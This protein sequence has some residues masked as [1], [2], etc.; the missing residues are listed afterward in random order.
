[1]KIVALLVAAVAALAST[2][3][4]AWWGPRTYGYYGYYGGGP[5]YFD[6]PRPFLYSPTYY[7]APRPYVYAAPV[8]YSYYAPTPV[9]YAPPVVYSAPIAT[10]YVGPV[11]NTSYYTPVVT[12]YY[13]T[14]YVAP[15]AGYVR[16]SYR[17]GPYATRYRVRA[18]GF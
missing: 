1:M 11:V 5:G 13:G 2:P 3:A 16:A 6:A 12:S 14:G 8:S 7:V 9:V 17:V 4:D 15:A 10:A 18:V